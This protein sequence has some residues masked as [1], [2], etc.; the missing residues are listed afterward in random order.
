[1]SARLIIIAGPNGS[2]KSSFFDALHTWHKWTSRKQPSWEVDYHVKA[3]SPPRDRWRNDVAI[4]FHDTPS[5]PKKIFYVRSAYRNDPE[6]KIQQ[7][8]V[9][10]D[11]LDHVR[12]NR[13]IDNDAAIGRNYE[14]LATRALEDLYDKGRG[15]TT[16]DD[17]RKQSIGDIQAP[18]GRLFPDLTL[19][20]LGDP[21][22]SGTFTFTKGES[23]GFSFKNLSGGE[24]AA[25]DLILDMIVARHDYD[26]TVYCIDEPESHM[27]SR[28]QSDLVEVLYDLTP[29]NCQLIL[30]TH[31]IGMMRR[32]RDIEATKPN[33]VTFLDFED[34]D[35][36]QHVVIEPV[37]VNRR[38]WKKAHDV[39]LDD[40]ASLLAPKRVVICE[41]H[42]GTTSGGNWS[43]D[44]RCY[45]AIFELEF[46]DTRFV[47]MGNDH[48]VAGDRYGLA[49]AL[50]SIVDGLEVVR[51]IDRDDRNEVE[52]E[53]G[54]REGV[55]VLSRRNLESYLFD[56][57][58]LCALAESQGMEHLGQDIMEEK[59]RVVADS[60]GRPDDLKPLAQKLFASCRR[61]LNITQSGNSTKGFM[62]GTLAPLVRPGMQVYDEL[63]G[64]IFGI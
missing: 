61:V 18:L 62:L 60:C 29:A 64:D 41:G 27:N 19:D 56:D 44:A 35:F 20:G 59:A 34:L 21:L 3:G 50:L 39:A 53:D 17:Y 26:D 11:P 31:S 63:M 12:V 51:I 58:V 16:F 9:L 38:F 47:S 23:S 52:I 33:S 1:M 32:A 7:L 2:G 54:L 30:A 10:G 37:I 8:R 40:L 25:F 46:P 45:E 43:Y 15:S 55:R 13:M 22:K 6:F 28:I 5:E 57:E 42:P 48:Q 49:Q 36:D 4:E 14:R 24:K